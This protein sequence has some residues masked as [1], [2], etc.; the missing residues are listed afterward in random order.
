MGSY[1]VGI[2]FGT[3]NSLIAIY[4]DKEQV[5]VINTDSGDKFL[6]SVV[7]FKNE[8]EVIVG[9]NAKAVE[10]I[11]PE[12]TISNVKRFLGSDKTYKIYDMEFLPEDI[13]YFIFKK[14]KTV[15]DEFAGSN[16][17]VNAVV[18]VPAYFDHLQRES[19]RVAAE[20]AGFNVLLLVNEPTAAF[21]YYDNI[22]NL[23]KGNYFVFDLGGGTLDISL[24][25]SDEHFCKVLSSVGSTDI[26]GID[27]DICLADYF[28]KQFLDKYDINLKE[29]KVAYQ[30]LILQSERAKKELSNLKEINVVIPYITQTKNG[31]LHFKEL[32]TREQFKSI[33]KNILKKIEQ[34]LNKFK[35]ENEEYLKE[36]YNVLLVGGG[37]RLFLME[38]FL[39]NHLKK[40]VRKNLNPEEA[41]VKGAALIA[42][43]LSGKLEKKEFYDV[44]THNLGVEDDEGNFEIIIKKNEIYPI[45]TSKVFTNSIDNIEEI[46]VHVLQD[47]AITTLNESISIKDNPDNFVSLGQFS[48]E[49]DKNLKAGDAN[50]EIIFNI[51][52]NGIISIKAKDLNRNIEKDFILKKTINNPNLETI[53][54]L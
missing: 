40:A 49:I 31:V 25:E 22:Y 51:D 14:L 44:T 36:V 8:K 21:I 28:V 43:M 10:V 48:M 6:P 53:D 34:I 18:T 12:F 52:S 39:N 45:K 1:T 17:K 42:A 9:N 54:V 32:I 2:D 3:T 19:V 29:D 16:N 50:L 15:F 24:V 37:S 47:M 4:R 46:V 41:V 13:A 23:D 5:E 26:G 33:S 11:E 38:D 20:K 27:F 30:Q 35:E 7:Y